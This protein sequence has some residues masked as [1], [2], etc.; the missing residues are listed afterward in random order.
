MFESL[1]LL[2]SAILQ[3]I[4]QANC[5][6]LLQLYPS[7]ASAC[8]LRLDW[9]RS[10]P[11]QQQMHCDSQ[12]I[13]DAQWCKQDCLVNPAIHALQHVCSM[14]S[15][16]CHPRSAQQTTAA[17]AYWHRA[18][19]SVYLRRADE[20]KTCPK[21]CN[22]LSC[23]VHLKI[24]PPLSVVHTEKFTHI[25]QNCGLSAVLHTWNITPYWQ[26]WSTLDVDHW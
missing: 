7:P 24:E 19:I 20:D 14:A 1:E 26:S 13:L 2:I 9:K 15:E 16:P 6:V 21:I 22:V 11:I 3:N 25:M 23:L 4:R 5:T 17:Q 18:E 8:R 10:S 12:T